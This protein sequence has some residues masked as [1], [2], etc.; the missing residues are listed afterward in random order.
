MGKGR[1]RAGV[2]VEDRFREYSDQSNLN[3]CWP[4]LGYVG[5]NG[6]GFFMMGGKRRGAHVSAVLLDGREIPDGMQV[7]HVC[8]NRS[9]VNPAH[10]DV[11]TP[12]ENSL[13]SNNMAARHARKTHCIHGHEF[14]P[15]NTAIDVLRAS[16]R[17]VRRCRTCSRT[18][19]LESYYRRKQRKAEAA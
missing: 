5:S 2:R 10:L 9:C 7:D 17:K 13:R 8:R 14:S 15:E 11:V 18:R 19:A 1:A 3:G 4:W 12:R 16:G 6:Y